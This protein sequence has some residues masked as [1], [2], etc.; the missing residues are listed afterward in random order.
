MQVY[1]FM[2]L[3]Q[4]EFISSTTQTNIN[5]AIIV[6]DKNPQYNKFL[7]LLDGINNGKNKAPEFDKNNAFDNRNK[8]NK[9]TKL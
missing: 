1:H 7:N 8:P 3:I 5:N 2:V 4:V 6:I 9:Q